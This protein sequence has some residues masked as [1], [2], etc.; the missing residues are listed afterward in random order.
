[1]ARDLRRLAN[2]K[3]DS[4]YGLSLVSRG[5]ATSMV[6]WARRLLALAARAVEA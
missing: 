3:D 5:D 4:H 6:R 1:M 2:R